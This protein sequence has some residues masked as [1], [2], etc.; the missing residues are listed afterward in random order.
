MNKL[1]ILL[2]LVFASA[3]VIAQISVPAVVV[4]PS[5]QSIHGLQKSD[6]D[7][8]CGKLA[9]FD[10]V[11]EVPPLK[12]SNFADPVPVFILFDS[13]SIETPEQGEVS[14]LLLEYLRKAAD[15]HL[16]VTLL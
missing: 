13:I 2:V 3:T 4:D 15:E 14:R 16:A 12:F 11:E 9:S 7:V 10:S 8:R 1:I 5:G 6:F